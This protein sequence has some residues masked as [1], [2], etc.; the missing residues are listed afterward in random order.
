[1][2]ETLMR[3]VVHQDVIGPAL[4]P[5][6]RIRMPLTIDKASVIPI[7]GNPFISKAKDTCVPHW[8]HKSL[9]ELSGHGDPISFRHLVV[10]CCEPL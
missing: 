4:V 9:Q 2:A 5:A 3:D 1:V 8:W 7:A 10:N 6:L